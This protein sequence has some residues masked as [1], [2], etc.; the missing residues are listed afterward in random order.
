MWNRKKKR[1]LALEC[2]VEANKVDWATNNEAWAQALANSERR[3]SQAKAAHEESNAIALKAI[4]DV[5]YQHNVALYWKSFGKP[6]GAAPGLSSNAEAFRAGLHIKAEDINSPWELTAPPLSADDNLMNPDSPAARE[7]L[8]LRHG[9][10]PLE[11][12]GETTP[13]KTG[14]LTLVGDNE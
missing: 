8:H 3:F 9:L 14:H 10:L 1:I 6:S 2:L 11:G 13:P 7:A 12:G 4:K 5:E